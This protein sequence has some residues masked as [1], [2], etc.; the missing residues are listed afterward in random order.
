MVA[1]D[2][3][4]GAVV[5]LLA[6]DTIPSGY[7]KLK[8]GKHQSLELIELNAQLHDTGSGLESACYDAD[9][10]QTMVLATLRRLGLNDWTVTTD[11]SSANEKGIRCA[12]PLIDPA[13]Q[14]VTLIFR[15]DG[16]ANPYTT[17]AK[18]IHGG[19]AAKCLDL[20]Q[21]ETLTESIIAHATIDMDGTTWRFT[22]GG[23]EGQP[24][25]VGM[26][27]I[28]RVVEPAASCTR[29]NVTVGG[30]VEIILRGPAA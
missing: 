20:D 19:L 2:N 30:S 28:I 1:Y 27:N 6:T 18:N 29:A 9:T 24:G 5:V 23:G 8:T 14:T 7:T 4:K 11:R 15:G 17:F 21:A 10:A 26:P 25:T 16:V 12:S 13:E 22:G 3:G